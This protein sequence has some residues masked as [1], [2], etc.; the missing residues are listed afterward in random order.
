[1]LVVKE[2]PRAKLEAIANALQIARYAARIEAMI[3]T[4]SEIP[5]AADVFPHSTT[6]SAASTSSSP[7]PIPSPTS[8]SPIATAASASSRSC[9]R[10]RSASAARSSTPRDRPRCWAAPSSASSARSAARAPRPL[11]AQGH[12][13]RRRSQERLRPGR[14]DLRPRPRPL[15]SVHGEAGAGP[16]GHREAARR[17]SPRTSDPGWTRKGRAPDARAGSS[18]P[19]TSPPGR[20]SWPSTSSSRSWASSAPWLAQSFAASAYRSAARRIRAPMRSARRRCQGARPYRTGGAA[21]PAP[22]RA[23]SPPAGCRVRTS[24]G[25]SPT[26]RRAPAAWPMP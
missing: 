14:E 21:P 23:G 20:S 8:P 1:M 24:S 2:A 10:R 13:G 4:A 22:R 12:R 11:R 16:R 15:F 19:S 26:S 7:A 25:P 5:R 6:M 9:A 18:G 17:R 3:L